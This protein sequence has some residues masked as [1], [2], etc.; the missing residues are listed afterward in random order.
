MN[1][2]NVALNWQ[3]VEREEIVSTIRV[4]LGIFNLVIS[5]LPSALVKCAQFAGFEGKL[6]N[7]LNH[8]IL[9]W[10]SET[11]FSPLAAMVLLTYALE[12]KQFLDI[13]TEKEDWVMCQEILD[14]SEKDFKDS[15]FF[16]L[17]R[18]NL[19]FMQGDPL[20]ACN[21]LT[22]LEVHCVNLP[23][24]QL[25]IF[26]KNAL[27]QL[28]QMKLLVAQE[29]FHRCYEL[30]KDGGRR[31][32]C[33]R[34][35]YLEA[36]CAGVNGKVTEMDSAFKTI[37]NYSVMS[38]TDWRP[39][40]LLAMRKMGDYVEAKVEPLLDLLEIILLTV[41]F[42]KFTKQALQKA[43]RLLTALFKEKNKLWNADNRIRCFT[44]FGALT[45]QQ[46]LHTD[47]VDAS[48]I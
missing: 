7:A 47:E 6:E 43:K 2:Q 29:Y 41:G 4:I 42:N 45:F 3:G 33:P 32:G 11:V 12:L 17:M 14:W 48:F 22:S 39:L 26:W 19:K 13:P 24:L 27:Y 16:S 15:I 37:K 38:K 18:S 44:F 31:S 23:T 25:P 1:I 28:V 10:K 46:S 8:L 36:L 20:M 34:L 40:D 5:I 35:I 9:T 21:I 30:N